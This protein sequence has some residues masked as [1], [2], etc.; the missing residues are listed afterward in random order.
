[1]RHMFESLGYQSGFFL[2]QLFSSTRTSSPSS[3]SSPMK[4]TPTRPPSP[5]FN[6]NHAPLP[7]PSH[8][9][10]SPQIGL[11]PNKDNNTHH[12]LLPHHHGTTLTD[13]MMPEHHQHQ[14]Q[15]DSDLKWPNGLSLFT[16]L[17]GR[18]DDAK[19]LFR[20]EGQLHANNHPQVQNMMH[21]SSQMNLCSNA[22]EGTNTE[23]N[24]VSGTNTENYLGLES[25][26]IRVRNMES[27]NKFKRSF[28]MPARMATSSSSS[29]M[30]QH[31]AALSQ[32][33]EYRS[34]EAGIYSDIMET[35]LE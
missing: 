26:S 5:L 22:E 9:H 21:S 35:F 18:S 7:L 1:M 6:W 2:S 33:M 23:D 15:H 32:G 14:H 28:T 27:S 16:A 30:D 25:H 29:S 19:L 11:M 24:N 13:K 10:P 8:F 31:H 20:H 4:Q 17:T 3:S 12:F 34:S